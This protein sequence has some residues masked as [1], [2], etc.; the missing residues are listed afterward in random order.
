MVAVF[1]LRRLGSGRDP[2]AGARRDGSVHI[3][4][5]PNR[6]ALP[7]F[8]PDRVV[9]VPARL[10]PRGATPLVQDR[11][12]SEVVGLLKMLAEYQW[13]AA[14]AIW[15][16]D[17]RALEQALASNPLVLSLSLAQRMLDEVEKTPL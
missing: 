12:P 4:N 13:L 14:D 7:D 17:R 10:E 8:A 5:V 6:G 11:L 16:E 15:R 9:E 3:L 2:W 1:P